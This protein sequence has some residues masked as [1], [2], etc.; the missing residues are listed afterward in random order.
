MTRLLI[1]LISLSCLTFTGCKSDPSDQSVFSL[2]PS[3]KTG[4]T[5]INRLKEQ[6]DNNIIIS[7]NF[8]NGSGVS[9]GDINNDGLVDLY[10]VSN[11]NEN[12][13]YLNKG[14]F[15]F[16]DISDRTGV[17]G[18]K[19]LSSGST[20][21]DINSDGN[22]D[23]YVCYSTTKLKTNTRNQLFINNGDLT[24]TES[25]KKY[26]LHDKGQSNQA[27]FLD[28]DRDGD[29]DVFMLNHQI[30]NKNID[31]L[32]YFRTLVSVEAGDRLYRN[33]GDLFTDVTLEAGINSH[34]LGYGLG[35]AVGDF[36]IDGYPDIY[37]SNDFIEH[38]YLYINNGDGTFTESSKTGL[39][40]ISNFSMGNDVADINNDG[41]P[42]IISLDMVAEDNYGIKANMSG[43]DIEKFWFTVKSGFHHQYMYNTLQLNMGEAQFSEVGQLAGV[44]STDWSWAPLLADFD[45]D[46]HKD[47]FITNGFRRAFRNNDFQKYANKKLH[48]S[49]EVDKEQFPII[50]KELLEKMPVKQISNYMYHNEGNL[51]FVN[52]AREW[53]LAEPSFSNGAAYADLDNDG[54]LDLVVNNI[55][56]PAFVYRNNSVENLDH[57]Y[58]KFTFKGS[59]K[60][61]DGIGAKVALWRGGQQ[62]YVEHYLTRGYMSSVARGL[63]FGLGKTTV[64]DSMQVEWPG[65]KVQKLKSLQAD[66]TIIL[67]YKEA[68]DVL[69]P[70]S[71]V[72]LLFADVSDTYLLDYVHQENDFDDYAVQVLL[73]HKY[74][75]FGPSLSVAD[76]NKDGLEDFYVGG[77]ANQSGV[78][79][80]QQPDGQF[81]ALRGPWEIHNKHEDVSSIFFDANADGYQDLLVVSGGN[82]F[83]KDDPLLGD[84]LYLND[85]Q[86]GF[87]DAS[88]RL[89][90][91]AFSGSIARSC[92]FDQDGD[93]DLFIGERHI[94]HH[95]PILGSGY[96]YENT[97]GIFKDVTATKAT[98]LTGIGLVTDATW[99]D[100]D[101]DGDQD[102]VVVGE[103]MG[104]IIYTNENGQLQAPETFPDSEGW[105]Y[106]VAAADFDG[107]GDQD[108]VGGNLGLNYK[109]RASEEAP[110]E[111]YASDFDNNNELDIILSFHEGD[112]LYPLR[113]REC[114][115]EQMPYI[116]EKFPTY[117]AFAK[118]SVEEVLGKSNMETA[119]NRRAVTFASTYYENIGNGH[120]EARI[121]PALAQ[122]SS[123]NAIETGDFDGDG[124]LDMVLSGNL[125]SSEVETPR[126]DASYGVY[127]KGDGLGGFDAHY[128]YESGLYADGDVKQTSLIRIKGQPHLLLAINNEPLK[129]INISSTSIGIV[130]NQIA[131][132]V[133]LNQKKN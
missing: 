51:S 52:K 2:L 31:S 26:G 78:L 61:P 100:I 98:G 60:N 81:K 124:N 1:L 22:L 68:V 112:N 110:F 123:V 49:G 76:V 39:K 17:E 113:G 105:W 21:V 102:L 25:A 131:N 36:N 19:G 125:Y 3:E 97:G 27:A 15:K 116:K 9:A 40:H 67:D 88:D 35:V 28:Y 66:R 74:S 46:G 55:D 109:Y 59:D 90:G 122:L 91:H 64:I 75:Q 94:P 58:L 54:D 38:D 79:Y 45:N 120:F 103:W 101:G 118:A 72:T 37:V 85:G 130:E 129:V 93:E 41:L 32:D 30:N 69:Q 108:L 119:L 42:D 29:L 53:G 8:Y 133:E 107:D 80:E 83:S 65:G 71:N 132:D 95:Y 121:L 70:G 48:G 20:M 34:V 77:A 16:E 117:D 12:K 126:N 111:V 44:S 89:P 82:E 56:Q 47:L 86:G 24:F 43:M 128:P 18:H 99:T 6:V 50:L 11:Q 62:Q 5:F 4:I 87:T 14:N 127:L 10:F 23:I 7:E 84:R 106:S 63:H 104:V 73:P 114:S 96:L 115:S 13:L 92:D 57:H 33:D